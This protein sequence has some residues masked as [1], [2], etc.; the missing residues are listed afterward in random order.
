MS[1]AILLERFYKFNTLLWY[2]W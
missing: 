2:T 1:R